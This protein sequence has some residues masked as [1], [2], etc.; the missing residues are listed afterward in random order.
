MREAPARDI[1]GRGDT[2]AVQHMMT[3]SE[4]GDES[5]EDAP[6]EKSQNEGINNLIMF[7]GNNNTH[8]DAEQQ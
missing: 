4:R 3:R 5:Y 7:Q 2:A 6:F 1:I 8:D